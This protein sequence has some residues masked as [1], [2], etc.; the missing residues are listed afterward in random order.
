MKKGLLTSVKISEFN[1]I[2]L[3][4]IKN[5]KSISKNKLRLNEPYFSGDEIT[6]IRKCIKNTYVSSKSKIVSTFEKKISKYTKSKFSI[7]TITGTSSLHMC[8]VVLGVKKDHE[9]FLPSFN[10]ISAAN[11]ITYCGATPHFV[12]INKDDLSVDPLKLE[13]Y[14]RKNFIK[15]RGFCFNKKTKKYVKAII[16]P[17]I[18]GHPAKIDEII[19]ISKKYKIKV[20]EDAAESLGSFYKKKHTGTF[21]DLGVLSF[22]G[23][24]ILTTG[25]GG[26]ILTNNKSYALRLRNL[27][28]QAKIY[29]P[30]KFSY[31]S[32]G[33]N[34][35]MA[36][37]NASLGLAQIK[38]I[39][40]LIKAKRKLYKIYKKV[41]KDDKLFK[42]RSEPKN[43]RSNYWLNNLELMC[44]NSKLR[45]YLLKN[46]NS[47]KIQTRPAWTLIHEIKHFKKCPRDNLNV[48]K[49][50]FNKIISIP[51]SPG[52]II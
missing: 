22:N 2:S 16:V 42:L 34:L 12:D 47:N 13:K 44:E 1:D 33:Y 9:V 7:A 26:A 27:T 46:T 11:S 15:K 30:Y 37:I 43:C 39:G 40:T 21:G 48:S 8:L 19:K 52:L 10:F 3:D 14:L 35:R 28:E 41:F 5:L 36:G 49:K 50:Y 32:I 38:K 31:N 51:S 29:H 45:D 18:F 6:Q 23:N 24:K 20:I 17:H 4:L 25:A